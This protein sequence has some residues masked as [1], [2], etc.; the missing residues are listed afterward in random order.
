LRITTVSMGSPT[1]VHSAMNLP[2]Q[3]PLRPLQ[4]NLLNQVDN[5]RDVRDNLVKSDLILCDKMPMLTNRLLQMMLHRTRMTTL[6]NRRPKILVLVGDQSRLPPTCIHCGKHTM[7]DKEGLGD[8]SSDDDENEN[9]AN[10]SIS[11]V[12]K[13]EAEIL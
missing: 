12:D 7:D 3:G 4:R 2:T 1:T 6:A 13:V 8:Y 9:I 5:K 10:I 11:H